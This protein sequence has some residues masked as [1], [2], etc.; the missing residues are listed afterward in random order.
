MSTA[1]TTSADTGHHAPTRDL[2]REAHQPAAQQ[3][4]SAAPNL[5]PTEL[6]AVQGRYLGMPR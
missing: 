4:R 1:T 5:V 6:L 3:E 2:Q